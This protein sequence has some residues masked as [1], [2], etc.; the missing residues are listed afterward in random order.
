[1]IQFQSLKYVKEISSNLIQSL[2]PFSLCLEYRH[3]Q[4]VF[5]YFFK[6]ASN[7]VN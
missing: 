2:L 7:I 5:K 3:C 1:M 4:P 6:K